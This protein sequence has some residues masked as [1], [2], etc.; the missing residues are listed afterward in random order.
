MEDL[1]DNLVR[2]YEDQLIKL[3]LKEEDNKILMAGAWFEAGMNVLQRL[4]GRDDMI[5]GLQ[6]AIRDIEYEKEQL[7]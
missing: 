6:A 5:Q 2:D 4:V 3:L 7:H 1:L